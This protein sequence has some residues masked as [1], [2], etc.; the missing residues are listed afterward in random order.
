MTPLLRSVL[1]VALLIVPSLAL[2]GETHDDKEKRF[3]R[4]MRESEMGLMLEHKAELEELLFDLA[5]LKGQP[6]SREE[7]AKVQEALAA[8][9]TKHD[10]ELAD[11][12]ANSMKHLRCRS[13][14]AMP[15]A[16]LMS[17]HTAE[18]M[19]HADHGGY[20]ADLDALGFQVEAG[21]RY[22]YEVRLTEKGF[23]ATATGGADAPGDVWV[24]DETGEVT[25]SENACAVFQTSLKITESDRAMIRSH[26]LKLLRADLRTGL[27]ETRAKT[28]THIAKSLAGV[29]NAPETEATLAKTAAV[30]AELL[31]LLS[32]DERERW[33]LVS[34][35]TQED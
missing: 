30:H 15:M 1:L 24:V 35:K 28:R 32:P 2:A 6:T 20:S 27:D 8:A 12:F 14:Q 31:K 34:P 3:A 22:V 21:A 4:L 13:I 17:L 26:Y 16:K 19:H 11:V 23:V 9:L 18:E 5:G 7:G 25:N 33:S 10:P 29:H